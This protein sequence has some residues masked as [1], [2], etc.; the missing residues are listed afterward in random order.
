MASTARC[1]KNSDQKP[2]RMLGWLYFISGGYTYNAIL[3]NTSFPL[4]KIFLVESRVEKCRWKLCW[5]GLIG[6]I[7]RE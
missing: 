5:T 7:S 6:F 4:V 2:P 1:V 3:Y